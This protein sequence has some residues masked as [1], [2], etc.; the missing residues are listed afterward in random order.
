M[1]S[2]IGGASGTLRPA[3]PP[4]QP[5]VPLPHI[6]LNLKPT[7]AT[8]K[9][10]NMIRHAFGF[11]GM[12]LA[13]VSFTDTMLGQKIAETS[14]Q[15]SVK[16]VKTNRP[17]AG[18]TVKV[19]G[20]DLSATS[21]EGGK[22]RLA[23]PPNG[24]Q[25]LVINADGYQG[26]ELM[27]ELPL[28]DGQILA[29]LLKPTELGEIDEEVIVI[30]TTRTDSS[31]DDVPTRIE[32][33][34]EEGIDEKL[35]MRPTNVSM[36]L[37]ESTGIRVQ[38]TSATSFTQDIRIQGLDG[39]YT[40]IL[41]D[42]FPS[43]GGFSASLSVL[44]IPPL[45]LKQVEIIK[46]ASSTFYGGGAIAGV[47]NFI[48]KKPEGRPVTSLLFNQTSALG[49]D[50]SVFNTRRF[51]RIGYSLF[52]SINYQREYDADEDDFTELPRAKSFTL[53]PRAFIYLDGGA[54]MVIGNSISYQDREGGDILFIK[55]G[56]SSINQYFERNRT[57]RNI[58][59]FQYSREFEDARKLVVK[60][61]VAFFTREL[62]TP[63]YE[64]SGRQF[65]SYSD[66]SY[67]APVGRHSLIIGINAMIDR[68]KEANET[69]GLFRRD[70]RNVMVGAYIQDNFDISDRLSVEA[71]FRLDGS[72]D[73]GAFA[74][75]RVSALFRINERL[76]SRVGFG[77][78]YKTPSIF[79]EAAESRLFRNVRPI[80]SA[81]KAEKSKGGTTDLNYRGQIGD[82]ITYSINQM[83]FYTE[84]TDPLVLDDGPSIGGSVGFT[85]AAGRVRTRGAET[86]LRVS[87]DMLKIFAGYTFT[88]AKADHLVSNK[89]LPLTPRGRLNSALM[90]E[91]EDDFKLGVEIYYTSR[92][93]LSTGEKAR[94]FWVAGLYGE[95][96]FGRF[97]LFANAENITDTRQSRFGPVVFPP[98]EN[99][100]FAE[101][102]THT[103]GRIFNS[104]IKIRL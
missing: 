45:D 8:A 50:F 35:I 3:L 10:I 82:A 71:G 16:E 58:S 66:V 46:G 17:I 65:N 49:T 24:K 77:F 88:D 86:N 84:I 55:G 62:G 80:G 28:P 31:I 98:R 44:D 69:V 97:S 14:L 73:H 74:L 36:L 7:Y 29:V 63:G 89:T 72:K 19:N 41:K 48:S 103:E 33:V 59:T 37:N 38:Q 64:F 94:S 75:P 23:D 6:F 12:L 40:Q 42:G 47:V 27:V 25:K 21:D 51:D 34:D 79:T 85:N 99:P 22:V 30:S 54:Q 81:L 1:V 39:R 5:Y 104:G 95:K 92:Q 20:F 76:S 52:G 60:Q 101:I 18:A 32:V 56:G 43:F 11:I 78:G 91:R 67:R 2:W 26:V 68:F 83:F 96:T 87:Y 13:L 61:S 4:C 90:L 15:I 57:V 9:D 93:L 102:Y 53:N 70:E 100:T